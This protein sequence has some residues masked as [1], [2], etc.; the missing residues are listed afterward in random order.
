MS[1]PAG[2]AGRSA[3]VSVGPCVETVAQLRAGAVKGWAPEQKAGNRRFLDEGG[4]AVKGWGPEQK[5]GG[6]EIIVFWISHQKRSNRS[7]VPTA[8]HRPA[9][10]RLVSFFKMGKSYQACIKNAVCLHP[11]EIARGFSAHR[12]IHGIPSRQGRDGDSA[13]ERPVSRGR[14]TSA[15]TRANTRLELEWACVIT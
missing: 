5:A 15:R 9:I 10:V 11:S 2:A 14:R 6:G 13:W 8:E 3:A 7:G 4:G 12:K 1:P